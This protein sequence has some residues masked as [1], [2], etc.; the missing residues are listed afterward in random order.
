[1]RLQKRKPLVQ[2][3]SFGFDDFEA[4]AEAITTVAHLNI[5]T[6]NSGMTLSALRRATMTQ[7]FSEDL[8]IFFQVARSGPDRLGSIIRALKM[9]LHGRRYISG[10]STPQPISWLKA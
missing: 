10:G 2:G 9:A 3:L 7:S 6:E 1:M 8:K 5:A 4:M